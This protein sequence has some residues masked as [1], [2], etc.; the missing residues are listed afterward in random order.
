[1]EEVIRLS[2]LVILLTA[3]ATDLTDGKIS[4][5]LIVFGMLSGLAFRIYGEGGAGILIFLVHISIP[6]ILFYLLFQMRALGAGDIKLFSVIGSFVSVKELLFMMVCSLFMGAV[7]GT[8]KIA[9]QRV[10][11]G[12]P[13]GKYTFM[14]F[15][16]AIVISYVLCTLGVFI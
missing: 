13:K 4:N 8:V 11:L 12:R 10:V 15:S 7:L 1:M 6:V 16:I 9:Y 5:R 14:H 2:L 3:A